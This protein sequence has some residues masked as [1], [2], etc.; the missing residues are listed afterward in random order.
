MNLIVTCARNL[1]GEAEEEIMDILDELGDPDVKISVS[2]MSGIITIQ[3]KL[4]PIEVVRKMK[5]ILL[6]EPWS[7]RYCLRVIPIQKIVETNL[8]K[9]EEC[10][11]S[12]SDKIE[13][14]E[15]YRILIEKRNSDI[16]SKEIITNIANQIKN[17]VSLDFPD[18]IILIEILG[19]V[20]G[21]S[22]IKKSDILSLEKTKRSMSE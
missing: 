11:S 18:K 15:S 9:I 16:S 2:N 22:L 12:I 7:I 10:I 1:E 5:E 4:D 19:I 6:D 8:E 3:T 21:I 13:D 14:N 17:K 20:T